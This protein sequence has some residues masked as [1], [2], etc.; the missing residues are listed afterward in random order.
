MWP[1]RVLMHPPLLDQD[2]RLLERIEDLTFQELLQLTVEDLHIAVH[3]V[4]TPSLSRRAINALRQ[5]QSCTILAQYARLSH[6]QSTIM[7]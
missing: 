4:A 5:E 6:Y 3:C 2:L 7:H 1:D